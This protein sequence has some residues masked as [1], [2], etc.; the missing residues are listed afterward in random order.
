MFGSRKSQLQNF[1]GPV[2]ENCGTQSALVHVCPDIIPPAWGEFIE[3]VVCR[4]R[5]AVGVTL[6]VGQTD[7]HDDVN[8][9]ERGQTLK[10]VERKGPKVV[11]INKSEVQSILVQKL[12]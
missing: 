7:V 10:Q 4:R 1:I 5:V 12:H 11:R 2:L 8:S 3:L 9:F 6:K